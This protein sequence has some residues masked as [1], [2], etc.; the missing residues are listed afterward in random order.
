MKNFFK[1]F[2]TESKKLCKLLG[3][4]NNINNKFN[5]EKTLKNL[6]KYKKYLSKEEINYINTNLSKYI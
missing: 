3:I 1:N 5:L 2:K 6:Y 4:K